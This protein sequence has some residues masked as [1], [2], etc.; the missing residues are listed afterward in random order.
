[1]LSLCSFLIK[2]LLMCIQ[3]WK[4][5]LSFRGNETDVTSERAATSQQENRGNSSEILEGIAR[6]QSDKNDDA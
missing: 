1:M 3:R 5:G 2:K 4:I 6:L